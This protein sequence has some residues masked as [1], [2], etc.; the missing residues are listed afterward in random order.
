M[1]NLIVLI[2]LL[3]SFQLISQTT[4]KEEKKAPIKVYLL[5]TFHFS[6]TD[7]SYN[8]V[9]DKH[10]KSIK[11]LCKIIEK[12]QPDKIFTERQPEFEFQNK[13]DDKYN[14]YLKDDKIRYKNE[15]YQVG[16]RVAKSLK[17]PRIYQCDHPGMYGSH[18]EK[19]VEYAT[20]NNQLDYLNAKAKGTVMRYDEIID[21]DSLMQNI[22]LLEYIK[23]INSEK[24]MSTSHAYYIANSPQIGSKDYYNSDDDDTLIGAE[25]TADWYRR[26]IMIYTKMINQLDYSEKA[27]F[28]IIGGDHVPIL[29]N[30]FRD[31]PHFEVVPIF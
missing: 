17:H 26:N 8:I 4:E 2:L 3:S 13:I 18:Y 28:L 10:Q 7:E 16:F 29:R 19:G 12:H 24:V 21:E 30:L 9:D 31:N 11:E 25:L 15:I 20:K 5:G 14:Q 22:T 1:K 6:Q 27:I 23:W